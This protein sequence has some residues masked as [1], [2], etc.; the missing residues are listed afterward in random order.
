M[1]WCHNTHENGTCRTTLK[2]SN[3]FAVCRIFVVMP[4]DVMLSAIIMS[5]VILRNAVKVSVTTFTV[6]TAISY[7]SYALWPVKHDNG[8]TL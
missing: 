7:R 6:R 4:W 8:E 3:N 1:M 5:S 2:D